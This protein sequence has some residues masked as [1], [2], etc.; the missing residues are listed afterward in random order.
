M[1]NNEVVICEGNFPS[2]NATPNTP[3]PYP[4]PEAN[5]GP[6]GFT[7]FHQLEGMLELGLLQRFVPVEEP[8]S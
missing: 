8:V 1:T 6:E 3:E 7:G 4:G 2:R 5:P